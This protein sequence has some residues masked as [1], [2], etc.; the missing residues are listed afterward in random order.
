MKIEARERG[1]KTNSKLSPS[2]QRFC[3]AGSQAAARLADE[4]LVSNYIIKH[5]IGQKQRAGSRKLNLWEHL[6]DTKEPV[7]A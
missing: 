7:F 1:T 6:S 3:E 5:L 4:A 2:K